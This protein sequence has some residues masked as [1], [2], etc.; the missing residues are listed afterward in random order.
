MI[1]L[2]KQLL[3]NCLIAAVFVWFVAVL[4][5]P[6]RVKQTFEI[7]SCMSEGGHWDYQKKVCEGNQ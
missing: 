5:N 7:D 1:K 2:N 6:A 3:F 4:L